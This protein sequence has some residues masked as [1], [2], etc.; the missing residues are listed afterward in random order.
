MDETIRLEDMRLFAR[1][2]ETKSLTAAA[3]HLGVSKQ[4]LSRRVAE[5][6]RA[7]GVQLMRRTTRRLNLTAVGT[8]YAERCMEIVRSAEEANR[9]VSDTHEVPSGT[10]RITADPVFGEAFLAELVIEYARQWPQVRIEVTLTRRRVDLVEEGFD[11]AFRIGAVNDATLSGFSLGAA[12]V[13]YCASPAYVARRGSPKTPKE[14]SDHECLVVASDRSPAVWPFRG[15]EGLAMVPVTARMTL[16]SFSMAR[17]AAIAGLGIAIFS[18]FA[19]AQDLL[20]KRL[21]PVLGDQPVDVGAISLVHAARR[22][23]PARARSF[24]DLTRGRFA[25]DRPWL[26]EGGDQ[27]VMRTRKSSRPL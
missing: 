22:F 14:L 12:R 1:V 8:A 24:V 20:E 25:R 17:A 26:V 6:E 13:Q 9:A 3:R 23:L 11:V 7:L 27:H 2:A 4:T 21:V 15:K 18:E 10:L 16:S 19:C 5:L